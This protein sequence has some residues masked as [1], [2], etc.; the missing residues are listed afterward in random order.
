MCYTRHMKMFW[1]DTETTGIDTTNS[2]VFEV[3]LLMTEEGVKNGSEDVL[4]ERCFFLNPLSETIVYH[5]DAGVVHGYSE[6]EILAMP[7]EKEIVPIIEELFRAAKI[8]WKAGWQDA[9]YL[10]ESDMQIAGYNVSFD[11]KHLAALFSRNGYNL[12]D[13][14]TENVADVFKQVKTALERGVLPPMENKK[15]TT[16]AKHLGVDLSNAHDALADIRATYEV[17]KKLTSM[18]VHLVS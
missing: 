6:E 14:F 18:G 1:I 7:S 10:M 2:S 3:G 9:D 15:L 13:Y 5:S 16:V 17:S 11:A 12:R 8:G 4:L